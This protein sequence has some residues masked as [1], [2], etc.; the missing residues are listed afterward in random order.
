MKK[1]IIKTLLISLIMLP[2]LFQV[3]VQASSKTLL[4]DINKD[5]AVDSKDLLLMVKHIAGTNNSEHK[6]WALEGEKY[7]IADI[8]KNGLVDGSDLL[9]MLR[10]I[11]A[12]ENPNEI[13]AM[14]PD[15]I[16]TIEGEEN[17]Y[18]EEG[19]ESDPRNISLLVLNEREEPIIPELQ[20]TQNANSGII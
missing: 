8:T 14:H 13:G 3:S 20:E 11:S 12:K 2:V 5:G 4:G 15:W 6:D 1:T 17:R 10:Y 19:K 7:E 9:V 16:E 18:E